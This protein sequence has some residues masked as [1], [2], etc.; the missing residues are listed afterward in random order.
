ME[1]TAVTLDEMVHHAAMLSL[2]A[3]GNE[4]VSIVQVIKSL[5][6]LKLLV[7]FVEGELAAPSEEPSEE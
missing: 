3:T 1:K 7:E 6:T 2:W 4:N 5:N